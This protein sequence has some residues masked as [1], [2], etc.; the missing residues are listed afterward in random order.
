MSKRS[1]IRVRDVMEDHFVMMDGI[2][3]AAEGIAALSREGAHTLFIR[4]RSDHDE[5]GIVVL[6]DIAK[7]VI[8]EDKSPERVNLY[9]IMTK[10]VLGIEPEMDIRYCA[11]L[12]YRFGLATAPVV[13]NKEIIGVVTYNELV[14]H[15]LLATPPK[16]PTYG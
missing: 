13:E 2:S 5:F 3:T 8:A 14:L 7:K 12:F 11:R 9:E 1:I 4:R 6:A 10:P 16:R 15:G